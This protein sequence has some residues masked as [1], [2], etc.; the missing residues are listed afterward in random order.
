MIGLCVTDVDSHSCIA[1]EI[2]AE[3]MHTSRQESNALLQ[4]GKHWLEKGHSGFVEDIKS[5]RYNLAS[6]PKNTEPDAA[7]VSKVQDATARDLSRVN[8]SVET[9]QEQFAKVQEE[10]LESPASDSIFDGPMKSYANYYLVGKHGKLIEQTP[11]TEP[12]SNARFLMK[13]GSVLIVASVLMFLYSRWHEVIAE[14]TGLKLS[15]ICCTVYATLSISID[16]SIKN[17][18]AAYGGS[19][20]FNPGCG[21]VV[22]EYTKL[23][24]SAILFAVHVKAVKARGDVIQ[25][26]M[27]KDVAWMAVPGAIYAINNLIVFQAI[28]ST[29]LATFGVIRETMLIW[30]ALLWTATFRQPIGFSRWLA[31]FGI[32]F[33]LLSKSGSKDA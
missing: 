19:F 3:K 5:E 31:I 11:A 7:L 15:H 23:M 1:G 21:V 2:H 8:I 27:L 16:L 9:S 20:P 33:W 32:F 13:T 22:V 24:A 30:N 12:I 26:P 18:A 14:R 17:A 10:Y 29:P 28:K 25:L 4:V 6:S